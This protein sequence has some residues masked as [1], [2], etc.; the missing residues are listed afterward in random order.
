MH[1][2]ERVLATKKSE[3]QTQNGQ[4]ER[5]SRGNKSLEIISSEALDNLKVVGEGCLCNCTTEI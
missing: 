5:D 4:T 2:S 1:F 3:E